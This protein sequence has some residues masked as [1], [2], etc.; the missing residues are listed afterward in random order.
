MKLRIKLIISSLFLFIGVSNLS[1]AQRINANNLEQPS[2]ATARELITVN[3]SD[4]NRTENTAVKALFS[5][6]FPNATSPQWSQNASNSFVSFLNNGRRASACFSAKG[7]LNYAITTCELD[8][9]P[10]ELR[11]MINKRYKTYSLFNATQIMAYGET[12]WQA[13]LENETGFITLKYTP[14]GIEEIQQ[15]KK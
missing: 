11:K 13:I 8:Q 6:L 2:D 10:K 7:K 9:L 5:T 4:N 3:G 1:Q 14:D 15:V 12:A